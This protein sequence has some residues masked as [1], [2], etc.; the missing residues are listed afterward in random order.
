VGGKERPKGKH[1]LYYRGKP[2][3]LLF[4]SPC[5][6]GKTRSNRG[7]KVPVSLFPPPGRQLKTN[8]PPTG[9]AK[10]FRLESYRAVHLLSPSSG[11]CA[12]VVYNGQ[13]WQSM[14]H[15]ILE[16]PFSMGRDEKERSPVILPH[17]RL[18]EKPA[19]SFGGR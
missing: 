18:L 9:M 3:S 11:Q 13:R 6:T 12:S 10:R 5:R 1:P 2:P 14:G 17:Y 8:P 16:A 15:E 19:L 4:S 7:K